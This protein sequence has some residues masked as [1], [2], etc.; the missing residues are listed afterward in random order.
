[1]VRVARKAPRD[2]YSKFAVEGEEEEEDLKVEKRRISA[3]VKGMGSFSA[4]W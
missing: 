1:M 2:H 3:W 4:S